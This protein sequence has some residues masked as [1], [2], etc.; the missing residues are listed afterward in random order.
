MDNNVIDLEIGEKN[1]AQVLQVLNED[2]EQVPAVLFIVK[3]TIKQMV[4]NI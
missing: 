1:I 2:F 4:L 3:I